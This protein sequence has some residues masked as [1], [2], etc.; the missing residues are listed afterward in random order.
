MLQAV[1]Q[2][3]QLNQQADQTYLTAQMQNEQMNQSMLGMV[4]GDQLSRD[5]LAQ[6]QSQFEDSLAEGARQFDD[7]HEETV[8]TNQE[9][10]RL[11]GRQLDIARDRLDF[12]EGTQERAEQWEFLDTVQ[13]NLSSISEAYSTVDMLEQKRERTGR[14]FGEDAENY[15]AARQV[16]DTM[17]RSGIRDM[18]QRGRLVGMDDEIIEN[19]GSGFSQYLSQGVPEQSA[20]DRIEGDGLLDRS[21][22]TQEAE[23]DRFGVL[24]RTVG[25]GALNNMLRF[26]SAAMSGFTGQEIVDESGNTYN[27]PNIDADMHRHFQD[28]IAG[29]AELTDAD[30]RKFNEQFNNY[31]EVGTHGLPTSR[32][33][34]RRDQDKTAGFYQ[35]M[36]TEKIAAEATQRARN[37]ATQEELDSKPLSQ[38]TEEWLENPLNQQI[39]YREGTPR[40]VRQ[41]EVAARKLNTIDQAITQLGVQEYSAMT[42]NEREAHVLSALD[43]AGFHGSTVNDLANIYRDFKSNDVF[44][45][46]GNEARKYEA[47]IE[48]LEADIGFQVE[49]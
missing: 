6:D 48:N 41:G 3:R 1:T 25:P 30:R 13:Q 5:Q 38:I 24:S 40:A 31:T 19:L 29:D 11:L 15:E 16:I 32:A 34:A 7:Q 17:S 20:T 21:S 28:V 39:A 37:A 45:F 4:M 10:E 27:V 23:E 22:Y 36:I 47:L 9:N 14:L 26:A 33:R 46:D 12:E 2:S 43:S 8:R 44:F 35:G 18:V 42:K 49:D